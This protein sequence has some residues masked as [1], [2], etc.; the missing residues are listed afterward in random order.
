M[1]WRKLGSFLSGFDTQWNEGLMIALAGLLVLTVF[2][3]CRPQSLIHRECYRKIV[4][5]AEIYA[6]NPIFS[7]QST[8]SAISILLQTLGYEVICPG[9]SNYCR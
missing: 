9:S 5:G 6:V 1:V 3:Q 8:P 4:Y 7:A 2:L